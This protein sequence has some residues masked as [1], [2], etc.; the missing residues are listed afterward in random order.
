MATPNIVPRANGQG[1]LGTTA[2]G[3]GG[4]YAADTTT[5]T[6]N[7]GGVLQLA[8]NDGAP[9]GDSHRLGVIYFKGAEDTS[10]TLTT[11]ARIEA[12]TDAAWTNAENGCALYFYTTDGNASETNVLK[13]DSNQKATFSGAVQVNGTLNVGTPKV[14]GIEHFTIACS[15]DTT[16]LTTG[17]AKATFRMPYAFVLTAVRASV[18]TAPTGSV[19]TVDINE[20]GSTI[21]STKLTI[22]ASEKTSTSAATAAVISDTALADDAEIT[23]DI[24]GVGSTV[25]GKGLK[26]TLI[27]YQA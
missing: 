19:L 1:S 15:D 2:K 17:T 13:L 20:G 14:T 23:I 4:L 7:T 10:G 26:V 16:L 9:M 11:G 6:A 21:L 12:L 24:D 18:S 22:D 27:G 25:A 3:W 5:S 8:A